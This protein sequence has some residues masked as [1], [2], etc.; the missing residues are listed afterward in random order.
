MLW[1]LP[2]NVLMYVLGAYLVGYGIGSGPQAALIALGAWL[3][4]V[5]LAV[6]FLAVPPIG[7]NRPPTIG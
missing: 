4:A 3:V 5:G 6:R 1:L 7:R 2:L